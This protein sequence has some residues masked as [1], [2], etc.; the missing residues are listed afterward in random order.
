[1]STFIKST[2][3]NANLVFAGVA[4]HGNKP[5]PSWRYFTWF[6]RSMYN[7]RGSTSLNFTAFVYVSPRVCEEWA[8]LSLAD[9]TALTDRAPKRK[10]KE[11]FHC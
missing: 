10:H 9:S 8:Y 7:P 11:H 1:M 6:H 3:T 2:M 4:Q 5:P